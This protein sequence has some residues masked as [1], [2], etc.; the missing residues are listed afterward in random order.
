[1]RGQ[2][3]ASDELSEAERIIPARAGPTCSEIICLPFNPDHPRSCGANP[4]RV[5]VSSEACGSSPLVRGQQSNPS[6]LVCR[7]RIIPARAGPTA[8]QQCALLADA[9]HPRSCGAN[10]LSALS[11]L[12]LC[13]SSPLVRGQLGGVEAEG[14]E[15]RII[16]ARAGPTSR[17]G[18]GSRSP[19]DHPRSCGANSN[20]DT[21]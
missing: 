1:M 2:L 8:L 21:R 15:L 18:H 4:L 17:C 20:S 19:S 5:K 14:E 6:R 3:K 13:G 16:P 10:S 11:G 9:D 7:S 12:A